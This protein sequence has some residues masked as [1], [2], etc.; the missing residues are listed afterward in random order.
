M[1]RYADTNKVSKPKEF[2]RRVVTEVR[3]VTYINNHPDPKVTEPIISEG[4]E[5]VQEMVVSPDYPNIT[6]IFCEEKTVDGR[7]ESQIRQVEEEKNN[8]EY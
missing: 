2:Q 7:R 4:F 5:T 3:R 8:R 6:P 1:F